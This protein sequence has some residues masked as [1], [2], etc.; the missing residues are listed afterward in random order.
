M[1]ALNRVKGNIG[2]AQAVCYLKKNRYKIIECNYT[3]PLGEIDI[4]AQ[5]ND[6]VVFV[7][8]KSRSSDTFGMP[9]EA[10]NYVKQRK[11]INCARHYIV[12]NQ[13][14]D[15]QVRFDCISILDGII[16]HIID[17]FEL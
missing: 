2:E 14:Y 11:I 6:I 13:L 8:V 5:K 12:S 4:V 10:I 7:E 1:K 3:C 15:I 16:T 9:Y 17:A